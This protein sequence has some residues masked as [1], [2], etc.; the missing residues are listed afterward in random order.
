MKT[1]IDKIEFISTCLDDSLMSVQMGLLAAEA[2]LSFDE[3]LIG[4]G[5]Q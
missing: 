3:P 1:K 4:A 2:L 5:Q